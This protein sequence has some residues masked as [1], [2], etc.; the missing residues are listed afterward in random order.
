MLSISIECW[1]LLSNFLLLEYQKY[2]GTRN[3]KTCMAVFLIGFLSYKITGM[4]QID[5]CKMQCVFC[6]IGPS[7]VSG[8][9]EAT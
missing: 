9:A 6:T 5:E 8:P 3:V 2:R 1:L 4:N 7:K